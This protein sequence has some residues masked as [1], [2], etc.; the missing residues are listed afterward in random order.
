[1]KSRKELGKLVKLVQ[2]LPCLKN[3]MDP[4][5]RPIDQAKGSMKFFK[6]GKRCTSLTSFPNSFLLFI[7]S[8]W[9]WK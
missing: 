7:H 1:M 2:R 9:N 4:L 3:F 6:H 8:G 5:L